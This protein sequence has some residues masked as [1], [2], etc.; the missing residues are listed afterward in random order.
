VRTQRRAGAPDQFVRREGETQS[1]GV[2]SSGT[3]VG[4]AGRILC[5]FEPDGESESSCG[6][7][8][9]HKAGSPPEQAGQSRPLHS[10]AIIRPSG[11]SSLCREALCP[12][13]RR[14]LTV[15]SPGAHRPSARPSPKSPCSSSSLRP[16]R[17]FSGTNFMDKCSAVSTM[18]LCARLTGPKPIRDRR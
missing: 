16:W 2:A 18:I 3:P 9:V 14:S 17:R 6:Q 12:R 7:Q 10:G 11:D 4:G 5:S 1:F 13:I 8:M 15:D